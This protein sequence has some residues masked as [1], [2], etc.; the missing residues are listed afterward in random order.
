MVSSLL[1]CSISICNMPGALVETRDR[2]MTKT[3]TVLALKVLRARQR[4][5]T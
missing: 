4:K 1:V 2:V 3:E 5:Y